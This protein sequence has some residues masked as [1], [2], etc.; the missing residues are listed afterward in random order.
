M[1]KLVRVSVLLLIFLTVSAEAYLLKVRSTSWEDPLIVM[2]YPVAADDSKVVADYI[3]NLREDDFNDIEEFMKK[4][5]KRF[6]QSLDKP[7]DV[8]MGKPVEAIP[9]SLKGN[10]N[11]LRNMWFSLKF[12]YW[13]QQ[14]DQE[15]AFGDIRLFVVYH[16]P[17][18]SPLLPHSLAMQKGLMGIVHVFAD[19]S[20]EGSNNFII[21]HEMLHTVGASDK[22]DPMTNLPVYPTGYALPHK[23]QRYPQGRAELMGGRIPLSAGHASI[24]ESLDQAVIG[25]LTAWE[26]NWLR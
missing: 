4:E 15:S 11:I 24:P 22:Y 26:I 10:H 1:W 17:E 2:V 19:E 16:D 6:F 9:P 25:G 21:A 14:H 5:A 20:L 12:R 23:I 13:A 8:Q 3:E 7:V 18:V